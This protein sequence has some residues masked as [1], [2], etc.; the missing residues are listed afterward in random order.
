MASGSK[1]QPKTARQELQERR[2]AAAKAKAVEDG[3]NL[4]ENMGKAADMEQQKM[5]QNVV[6]QA[7]AFVPGFD[8][9]NKVI[10][11]DRP[12]YRPEDIYR[13]QVNVDNKVLSRR[14]FGP[15]DQLH[16]EMVEAQ[17]KK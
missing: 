17:Y 9:Y 6:L 1:E 14:M 15:S 7:M 12:F 5:V 11:I 3:K 13:G 10:L 2:E 8:A 16:N 4:A